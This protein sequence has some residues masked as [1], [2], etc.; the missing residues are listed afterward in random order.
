MYK[1][2]CCGA[3]FD[4]PYISVERNTIE[5]H[6]EILRERLCPWCQ[7]HYF[8]EFFPYEKEEDE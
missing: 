1:C 7:G 2:E 8:K 4:E 3:T 6:T 5:G